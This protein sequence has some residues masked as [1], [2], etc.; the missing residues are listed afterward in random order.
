MLF[1]KIC[2]FVT[3][4]K[5][6]NY[7]HDLGLILV[8]INVIFCLQETRDPAECA[9]FYPLGGHEESSKSSSSKQ[10]RES[11]DRYSKLVEKITTELGKYGLTN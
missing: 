9:G 8:K 1:H 11:T 2:F 7:I 4:F 6:N 10:N 3:V 5:Y